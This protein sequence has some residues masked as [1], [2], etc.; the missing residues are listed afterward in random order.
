[1][2]G[3]TLSDGTQVASGD[4]YEGTV[5]SVSTPVMQGDGP[6]AVVALVSASG[7]IDNLVPR[8]ANACCRCS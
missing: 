6:I 1:M 3:K 4:I 7:E 5:F 8:S 2:V